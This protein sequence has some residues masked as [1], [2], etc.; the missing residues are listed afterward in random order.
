MEDG[1]HA[2]SR[3]ALHRAIP[4]A[5]LAAEPRSSGRA[6]CPGDTEALAL[7]RRFRDLSIAKY[8]EVYARLN[9]HFDVYSGES[10]Y[11]EAMKEQVTDM[12][13]KGLLQENE[14]AKICDLKQY[15]LGTVVIE[16]RDGTTLYITRDIVRLAPPAAPLEEMPPVRF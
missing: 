11:G 8:K 14:G 2:S 1:A 13:A 12:Q 15:K 6:T 7:W 9:V 4:G 16:K 5:H 3:L 10:L